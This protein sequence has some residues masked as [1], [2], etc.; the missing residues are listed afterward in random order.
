MRERK[1]ERKEKCRFEKGRE[2][3]GEKSG[4]T[5]RANRGEALERGSKASAR[6][7]LLDGM[8]LEGLWLLQGSH[9]GHREIL[10]IRK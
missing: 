4:T 7:L 6:W 1:V 8:S 10:P 5:Y 9:G 2:R 3:K